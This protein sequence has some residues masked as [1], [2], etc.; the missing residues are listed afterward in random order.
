MSNCSSHGTFLHFSL[1]KL[2]RCFTELLLVNVIAKP[3]RVKKF[4]WVR[5]FC[6][7]ISSITLSS[8]LNRFIRKRSK[9]VSWKIVAYDCILS[10]FS[11]STSRHVLN[12][13]HICDYNEQSDIFILSRFKMYI[14]I[15]KKLSDIN[16]LLNEN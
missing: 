2:P 7:T 12:W 11:M 16:N 9:Y 4:F 5:R 10:M 15:R 6:F 1:Q 13:F 8:H 3:I 14:A